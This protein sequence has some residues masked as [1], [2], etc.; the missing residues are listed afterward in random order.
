[1]FKGCKVIVALGLFSLLAGC[2]HSYEY[3]R[4]PVTDLDERDSGLQSRELVQATDQM[5]MD[6]LALP[7]LNESK[8]QW[9]IVTTYM[10]NETV[11]PGVPYNIFID[12]LKTNLARH[13]Q[14]RVTLIENKDRFHD[15]QNR[16]L[17]QPVRDEF[18]QGGGPRAAFP[19][20]I[21]PDYFLYG[22]MQEMPNRGTSTFRA[23]FNLV[24]AKTRVMVWSNE[25]LVKVAR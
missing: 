9:T 12:R 1:M 11:Q 14:G 21:Q 8:T 20:G 19:A 5:A 2:G 15:L 10:Q 24:N 16:E 4:P 7:A 22:K 18:G 23:E 17:E 13:G 3:Y 25:Y 6:L